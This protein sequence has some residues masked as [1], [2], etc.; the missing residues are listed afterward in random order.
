MSTRLD[1]FRVCPACGYKRGFHSSFKKEKNGI[2]LI[3]I[4]PNCGASF[5]IGLIENRIQE[6]NPVRGNNY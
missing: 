6:L 5:D 1:E 4:C 3:F 2:K